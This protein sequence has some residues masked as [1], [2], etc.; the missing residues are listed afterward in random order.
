MKTIRRLLYRDIGAS[1]LFVSLAFLSLFFFIDVVEALGRLGRPGYTLWG[2][3]R[4]ALLELPSHLYELLPITALIGTIY[5]LAK[6]AQTSEFTILRTSGLGPLRALRLLGVMGAFLSLLT[7][8]VGEFLV[9]ASEHYAAMVMARI[10]GGL[11]L[12]RNGTWLRERRSTPEGERQVSVNVGAAA[13]GGQLL[14]VRLFEFDPDGRLLTRVQAAQGAVHPNGY[15]VFRDAQ[16]AHWPA[17]AASGPQQQVVTAVHSSLAWPTTLTASVV[18][19]AVLPL[20]TM[21]AVDLWRYSKHLNLQDQAAQ[22]YEIRFWKKAT[23]PFTCLVMIA[24]ALPFA[25]LHARA[26]GISLKVFGGILLGISF[27]LVNNVAAHLGLL[28]NWTPWMAASLPALTY[29]LI[30]MATFTWLVRY[31]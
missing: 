24:L 22:R 30:S 9:P 12:E 4:K 18:A 17:K 20:D 27:V 2:V 5:A 29:L 21:G 7:F 13:D 14:R 15:W 11:Q 16:V 3:T 31:R 8:S 10:D 1:I 6:L 26:G 23:Y 25:Y 28:R 19:A